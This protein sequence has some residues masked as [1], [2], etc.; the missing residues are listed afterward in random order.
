MGI[1]RWT[2]SISWGPS[3]AKDVSS[4]LLISLLYLVN[5]SLFKQDFLLYQEKPTPRHIEVDS[6]SSEDTDP[7]RDNLVKQTYSANVHMSNGEKVKWH[8]STFCSR[9]FV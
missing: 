4:F 1:E 5:Q 8:L 7:Y 2:D 3:R 6:D 9:S